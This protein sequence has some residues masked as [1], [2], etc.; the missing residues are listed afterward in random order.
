MQP[1]VKVFAAPGIDSHPAEVG[2]FN[3]GAAFD[4]GAPTLKTPPYDWGNEAPSQDLDT[5]HLVGGYVATKA[6]VAASLKIRRR[7]LSPWGGAYLSVH[8]QQHPGG[9]T[10]LNPGSGSVIAGGV[11]QASS[12][13]RINAKNAANNRRMKL[14]VLPQTAVRAGVSAFPTGGGSHE[15]LVAPM[16]P[17]VPGWP[18]IFGFTSGVLN[19]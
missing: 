14:P 13:C 16:M 5:E 9:I 4:P 8:G 10:D 19:K 11:G 7:G 3:S 12:F 6:P 15:P 17:K 2:V 1:F 18:T